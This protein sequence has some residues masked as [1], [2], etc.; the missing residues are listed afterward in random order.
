MSVPNTIEKIVIKKW[1]YVR[2]VDVDMVLCYRKSACELD[3]ARERP[4]KKVV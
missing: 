1:E 4:R 3:I 2:F